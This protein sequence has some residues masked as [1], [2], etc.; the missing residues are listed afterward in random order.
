MEL[1]QATHHPTLTNL[2]LPSLQVHTRIVLEDG[3]F[4][5]ED[6]KSAFGTYVGLPKKKFFE[7][8]GG[9]KLLLGQLLPD[10]THWNWN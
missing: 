5:L 8:N 10:L 3:H 7:L 1:E 9:D 6:A 2:L 4:Y